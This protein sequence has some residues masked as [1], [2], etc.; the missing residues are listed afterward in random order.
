MKKTPAIHTIQILHQQGRLVEAQTG[1]LAI[2]TEDPHQV[3]ALHGL[4]LLYA[5]QGDLAHAQETLEKVVAL[6]SD[7]A[8]ALHLANVL[9]SRG[10][11]EEATKVLLNI[12][13]YDGNYAPAMNNLGTINATLLQFPE[14]VKWYQ[15]AIDVR[16]DYVDAYYNLGLALTKMQKLDRA[17]AA[18]EAVLALEEKH[19]GALFQ[20]GCLSMMQKNYEQA[21]QYFTVIAVQHPFHFETQV[22]LATTYLKLGQLNEAHLT[23][24]KAHELVPLDL[25][26]I[27]NLGVIAMQQG[28]L[29][30]AVE[31]YLQSIQLN[32]DLI[33]AHHNLAFAY[34]AM[35]Q[36]DLAL[37]HFQEVKRLDPDNIS[38]THTIHI[39]TNN[40]DI[41]TSPPDYVRSLFN[42]YA[43]HYDAHLQQVLH[44]QVPEQLFHA[45]QETKLITKPIRVLDLG[46]GTGLSGAQFKPLASRLVGVDIAE[47]MLD[48]AAEKKIYDQLIQS[49]LVTYLAS[50]SLSFDLVVAADVLVYYGD[51]APFFT[52]VAKVLSQG[53]IFIFNAEIAQQVQF[54]MLPSGRFAH[55]ETYLDY[56]AE[57]HHFNIIKKQIIPMRLQNKQLVSG[58]LY[59]L[60]K[61]AG[62][63]LAST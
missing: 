29:P 12:L 26:V 3:T 31:Y 38:V 30:E 55:S 39:L 23:Y 36:N 4:G 53:G 24:Q 54:E 48:L 15:Q 51:V 27:F 9:K 2:L 34:L 50:E 11:F 1:Y 46:S 40:K 22:N 37:K 18:F 8:P 61:S 47:N 5:E 7:S 59:I 41:V 42:S 13:K 6:T 43:D 21:R 52:G 62:N 19:S 25:Q 49:D 58:H 16:S 28:R 56:L 32:P 60:Q 17:K 14:A 10:L 35:R 45:L 33:D 20:S 57:Q 63:E 44:Y